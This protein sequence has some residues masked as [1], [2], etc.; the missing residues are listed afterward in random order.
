MTTKTNRLTIPEILDLRVEAAKW[1]ATK[2]QREVLTLIAKIEVVIEQGMLDVERRV[3]A[4]RK[5]LVTAQS[6]LAPAEAALAKA[7][8]EAKVWCARR[9]AGSKYVVQDG[10]KEAVRYE[11]PSH[12]ELARCVA[13]LLERR[14]ELEPVEALRMVREADELRHEDYFATYLGDLDEE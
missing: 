12:F 6:A 1:R 8:L 5:E 11:S 2:W 7:E 13:V 3:E 4:V 14:P 9:V 10:E